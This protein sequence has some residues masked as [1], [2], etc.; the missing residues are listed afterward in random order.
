MF[1]KKEK[2]VVRETK[3]TQAVGETQRKLD[4]T[5]KKLAELEI[6]LV[7]IMTKWEPLELRR[8]KIL[9]DIGYYKGRVEKLTA[10]LQKEVYY[11]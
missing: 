4:M 5:T 7:D 8:N 1:R 9:G 3:P 11:G 6:K 10:R 2:K